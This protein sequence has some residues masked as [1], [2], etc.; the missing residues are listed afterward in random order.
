MNLLGSP[1][2]KYVNNT[3]TTRQKVSG[4]KNNRS[5]E[6]ISY[7]NSRNAWVKL[8]SAV[9]VEQE[10]LDILNS[11][12]IT[13][14]TLLNGVNVGYDLA[15]NNVLQGGLTSYGSVDTSGIEKID[16]SFQE[17]QKKDYIKKVNKYT[18]FQKTPR[19]GIVG[20][21][22]NPAYGV[23]GTEFG[24]SPMPGITDVEIHDLNRGSIK[25]S[26]LNIKCHNKNQFDVI[27]VLYLRLGY[28]VC[29]EWGWD[30]YLQEDDLGNYEIIPV[31]DTLIDG[32]FWEVIN[33]DYSDFLDKIEKKRESYKGN[34]DGIIGIISN[35]SWSFE[36]DGTY[37]IKLEIISLG[38]VIESLKV[39]LPPLIKERIDPYAQTRFD[40]IKSNLKGLTATEDEFYTVLYPGLRDQIDDAYDELKKMAF[41]GNGVFD[42]ATTSGRG[43]AGDGRYVITQKTKPN[44]T[45]DTDQ[46]ANVD[47]GRDLMRILF[48][49]PNWD[50]GQVFSFRNSQLLLQLGRVFVGT[51]IQHP[52]GVSY[53]SY[54][55]YDDRGF[56]D[57]TSVQQGKTRAVIVY[58][59]SNN[60]WKIDN[61]LT[62]PGF[63]ENTTPK[64]AYA[65]S[66]SQLQSFK[67]YFLMNWFDTSAQNENT[68]DIG[69][70]GAYL[71]ADDGLWN[72]LPGNEKTFEEITIQEKDK[73]IF[74]FYT[75]RHFQTLF[76]ELCK[77]YFIAGGPSDIRFAK[78]DE[79]PFKDLT[80][81]NQTLARSLVEFKRNIEITRNKNKIYDYFYK[82]RALWSKATY[83]FEIQDNWVM[84][85]ELIQGGVEI[86]TDS[87]DAFDFGP[88]INISNTNSALVGWIGAF[89]VQLVGSKFKREFISI[90][91]GENGDRIGFILN[92][93]PDW[94]EKVGFPFYK[95]AND[96][97]KRY[98]EDRG[99]PGNNVSSLVG[100]TLPDFVKM[101]YA[102]IED[103][104]FIRFGVL[105]D[106]IETYLIPK[107]KGK[108][109]R[110]IP[111][112]RINTNTSTNIC[113][114]IDNMISTNPK[115][116]IIKNENF[117]AG[118]LAD[119]VENE[120]IF[121]GLSDFLVKGKSYYYGQI[122][123]IY[124]NFSR[125]EEIFDSVDKN[126]QVSLFTALKAMCNDINESLG[127]INNLEP[128]I[129]KELNEIKLIDQ[130]HIP[131]LEL[132]RNKL[133]R[134]GDLAPGTSYEIK[135]KQTPIE[136]YGYNGNFST[137]VRDVG[138]TTEISKN[139]ATAITI[140]A[141][142][143]GEIPG[144][145]ATAFSRWNIGLKDRFKEYLVDGEELTS[146]NLNDDPEALSKE[147]DK[148][149]NS[150][151]QFIESGYNKLG[152]NRNKNVLTIN[153]DFI[154]TNRNIAN[155]F[156]Q[157]AQAESTL[158]NYNPSTNEG[159]IES[160]LGFL[161]INLKLQ[162]D[163]L[164]GIR[165]YDFIKINSSFLPSNYPQTLEFI[166]TGVNHRLENNDWV[167]SLKT[168]AT[169]IDKKTKNS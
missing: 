100:G 67:Y 78:A 48:T 113:Y 2:R 168:I 35:F 39:N 135:K 47:G 167:T 17:G 22:S 63:L 81:E 102:P 45:I 106:F 13:G 76:Y 7:L 11:L 30:K 89:P 10:R 121:E 4:I 14:N 142:S 51:N 85:D 128:V 107:K 125:V 27:D 82:I 98:K 166:C 104:Y 79:D 119:K 59:N 137:F 43:K 57:A 25:K 112:I 42:Y 116:C 133:A 54:R 84:D 111:I 147:N 16:E 38:D 66:N 69:N 50:W 72:Q 1:L 161:P 52:G 122:M 32:K 71:G 74:T 163:G 34:Y 31:T 37:N 53:E 29:L 103:T 129:D 6:V 41:Q 56:Q 126:N 46:I 105:L 136:V 141:T 115:K 162:M 99:L 132:I 90:D 155:N 145:E 151:T 44:I 139:Y 19:S 143:Q 152:L 110:N 33:E 150:Y 118:T 146:K 109:N 148:V 40:D 15:I 87:G 96:Y 154:S 156:Y 77:R 117:Y 91:T 80:E 83:D 158:R 88:D 23:G 8:A 123:N 131:N 140:G 86:G 68:F 55:F 26:I 64:S 114:A 28:T 92:G 159:I 12:S 169:Y 134:T 153:S 73:Y 101:D 75:K 24:F 130:T 5:P 138:M 93:H 164:G 144:M 9:Y 60:E 160:S 20:Q 149:K 58:V 157:Y 65:F 62:S 49:N 165:I 61:F 127:N 124:L 21:S 120:I 97:W 70:S 94:D 95:D 36:N 3:I 108:G 18:N